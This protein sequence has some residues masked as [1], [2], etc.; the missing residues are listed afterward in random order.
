MQGKEKMSV[1]VSAQG[2]NE[3]LGK[4]MVVGR[5]TCL[6]DKF[7]T[8]EFFPKLDFGLSVVST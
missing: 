6:L 3:D 2:C 7:P 8:L 4:W 1:S 5:F